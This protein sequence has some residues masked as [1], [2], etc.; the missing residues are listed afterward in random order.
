MI[1]LFANHTRDIV[2]CISETKVP[3]PCRSSFMNPYQVRPLQSSD[4]KQMH[5]SFLEAFSGYPVSM[6]VSYPVFRERML[7]KL[8]INFDLSFGAFSGEK[9]VGFV[10]HSLNDYRGSRTVYNGGTGVIPGHRGQGLAV[11]LYNAFRPVAKT[12]AARCLLEVITT[13]HYA[14]NTYEKAGFERRGLLRCY[15][16]QNAP[17]VEVS[18]GESFSFATGSLQNTEKYRQLDSMEASFADS[19]AQ[20][21]YNEDAES[22]LEC[23]SENKLV[24]YLIFQATSGRITRMAVAPDFRRKGIGGWLMHRAYAVAESKNLTVINVPDEA[25]NIQDFLLTLGFENQ[26]DQWEMEL[27]L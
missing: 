2:L 25:K 13:N 20:L 7:R 24:G 16:L 26:I 11:T 10:F 15:K 17:A 23:Y 27:A 19:F 1:A 12:V 3:Q 4:L 6:K 5:R 9:L 22:V 14:I 18:K 8:N 21:V